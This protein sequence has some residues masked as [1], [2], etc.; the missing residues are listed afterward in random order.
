MNK[1]ICIE[2]IDGSG[3]TTIVDSLAKQGYTVMKEL[4]DVDSFDKVDAKSTAF[5]IR[6]LLSS[7]DELKDNTDI[8]MFQSLMVAL[9][10][11]NRKEYQPKL[12][13]MLK[14]TDVIMDRGILST[15]VYGYNEFNKDENRAI[16]D[17]NM[18][19]R[20]PDKV[21]YLAID[22]ETALNRIGAREDQ[23]EFYEGKEKL[24]K[25]LYIYN[26]LIEKYKDLLNI[27]VIDGTQDKDTVLTQVQEVLK[28]I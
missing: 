4:P 18:K 5:Q 28:T 26:Q 27:V 13:D 7:T 22:I 12:L 15:L 24:V 20:T 3:K 16:F 10:T 19:T 2:G 17:E 8:A 23:R 14:E 9:F 25:L 11:K 1:F 6:A 21:I